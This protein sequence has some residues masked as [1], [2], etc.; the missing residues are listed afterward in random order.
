M[1]VWYCEHRRML[2][3]AIAALQG[4]SDGDLFRE[5]TRT[6]NLAEPTVDEPQEQTMDLVG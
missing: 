2:D 5:M 4:S 1:E 6:A 3:R